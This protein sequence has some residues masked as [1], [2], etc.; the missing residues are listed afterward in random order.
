MSSVKIPT[1]SQSRQ[2][3]QTKH[4]I[5]YEKKTSLRNKK[6]NDRCQ[7]YYLFFFTTDTKFW[8]HFKNDHKPVIFCV[9]LNCKFIY[10]LTT[11]IHSTCKIT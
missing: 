4:N 2:E 11:L 5:L 3:P 10:F 1:H 9:T 8:Y 6:K 7:T